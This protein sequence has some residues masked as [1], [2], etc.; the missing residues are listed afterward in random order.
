MKLVDQINAYIAAK[1]AP[2]YFD[3]HNA[4]EVLGEVRD[5][6]SEELKRRGIAW[7][8]PADLPTIMVEKTSLLRILRNLIGNALK[9]GG[10]DMREIRIEYQEDEKHHILKI[11]DDG[12]RLSK[13]DSEKIFQPFYRHARSKGIEGTGLGLAIVKELVE[14]HGGSV[15]IDP[16]EKGTTF[17][18]SFA[19]SLP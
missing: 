12:V 19:K 14:R 2:L 5:E 6:F 1:E 4:G 15:W 18:V 10:A 7:N 11:S 13:E 16:K 17:C 9:H 3:L 8:A